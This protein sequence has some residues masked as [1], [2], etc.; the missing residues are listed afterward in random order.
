M[1]NSEIKAV[2]CR[3]Q[4]GSG[5]YIASYTY[6]GRTLSSSEVPEKLRALEEPLKDLL[7]KLDIQSLNFII[8]S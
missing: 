3:E 8:F 7:E 4:E 6:E 1:I 2:I 5:D